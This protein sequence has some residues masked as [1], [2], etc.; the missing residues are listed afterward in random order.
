MSQTADVS[1]YPCTNLIQSAS[2]VARIETA[3]HSRVGGALDNGSPV[4]KQGD[5]ERLAPE[6]QD[7]RVVF[8]RTV[9][10]QTRGNFPEIHRTAA[11]MNLYGVSSAQ[12]D[13]RPVLS[14]QPGKF[15]PF[16]GAAARLRLSGIDFSGNIAPRIEGEQCSAQLVPGA[17]QKL[18]GFG[19]L[20]GA[21]HAY[22]GI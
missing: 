20:Y 17:H 6:L 4:G 14:G 10:L 1:Q 19:R 13:L 12:R 22:G 15:T 7:K 11:L 2:N 16:T 5:L 8:H 18:N 9:G 3:G 21:H